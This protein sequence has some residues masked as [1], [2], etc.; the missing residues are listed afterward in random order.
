VDADWYRTINNFA[1]STPWLHWVGAQYALWGG[2]AILVLLLVVA[3]LWTRRQP[4]ATARVAVAVLTGVSAVAVLLINQHL[5]SPAIARPRPCHALSA[6]ETLLTCTNDYSMPSDHCIIA[7]ALAVGLWMLNWKFGV[8]A[9]VLALLLA[10]GRV[11]AGVHYPSDTIVGLVV[12]A[13]IAAIIVLA[14][15]HPLTVLFHRIEQTPASV[16]IRSRMVSR[17]TIG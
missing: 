13:A 14:L 7:G 4:D 5:I 17:A 6:V 11:Y 12:G 3:W 8:I 2:L 9:T 1:R 10:F 16:L 15:R